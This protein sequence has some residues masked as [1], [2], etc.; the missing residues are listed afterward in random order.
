MSSVGSVTH[1]MELVAGGDSPLAE[2]R[3]FER[4]F[5]RLVQLARTRLKDCPRAGEDEEDVALCALDSFFRRAKRGEFT[6]IQDR[7]DL[8]TLLATITNRKAI[9]QFHKQTAAKRRLTSLDEP[10]KEYH[11]GVD[12]QVAKEP[13]PDVLLQMIEECH[14]RLEQLH[15]PVL[16]KVAIRRLEGYSNGEIARELEV[17]DRTVRRKI[18][19]IRLEWSE[20]MT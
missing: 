14:K 20:A 15:D 4:F 3:L 17:S 19:R 6:D 11:Y 2:D 12:Q 8:W 7:S 13:P 1:W 5:E 9:N 18:D 16:R 10:W